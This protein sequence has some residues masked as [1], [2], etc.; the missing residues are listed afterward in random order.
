MLGQGAIANGLGGA[1]PS[2]GDGSAED[3]LRWDKLLAAELEAASSGRAGEARRVVA[4]T[5][6]RLAQLLR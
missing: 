2:P 6:R 3:Q 1:S 4:E 5:E